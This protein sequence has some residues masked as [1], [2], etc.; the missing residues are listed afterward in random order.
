MN[1]TKSDLKNPEKLT[2]FLEN[3]SLAA[4]AKDLRNLA[5]IG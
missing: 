2:V 1:S 4:S 3:I 5:V